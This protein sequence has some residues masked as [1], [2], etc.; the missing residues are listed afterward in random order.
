MLI[1]TIKVPE[2]VSCIQSKRNISFSSIKSLNYIGPL[3]IGPSISSSA[4]D[5]FTN[6]PNA[7]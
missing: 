4:K 1:S 7:N 2:N 3:N 6:L 5:G